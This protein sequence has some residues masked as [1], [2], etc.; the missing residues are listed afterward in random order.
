LYEIILIDDHSADNTADIATTIGGHRVRVL[1]L[2]NI[3]QNADYKD[4]KYNSFKKIGIQ[5]AIREARGA[6]IVCTD[7]DCIAQPDWLR[8]MAYFYE[9]KQAKFIAAPVNF[10]EETSVFERFQSLDFV[11]MMGITGAGI[12]RQFMNMCNGAN[13]AYP[14]TIF[15]EVGGFSGIDHIASGDDMLLMQKI[16]A[17]YPNDIYCL[18][19][20]KA[21]I[22]T[23]AK[24][25]WGNFINQRVR[26]AS[27]SSVYPERWVTFDLAMVFF[28]C[29]NIVLSLFLIPWIGIYCFVIQL[30]VKSIID[31]FFL[32][33]LAQYFERK[34]LM[35]VFLPSQLLHILYIVVVG[36]KSNM[37]KEYEWKGRKV[38]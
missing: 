27:K 14:K 16:A 33:D 18:K 3:L 9:H 13:L 29:C 35:R 38:K 25:T 12:H 2:E 26:W 4:F 19:H 23:H 17:Q 30:L 31:F 5:N 32:K 34:D 1:S 10:H 20:P 8:F 37:V 15:E 7:A 22:F 24:S 11:G 36:I 6:L 21:T 28:F